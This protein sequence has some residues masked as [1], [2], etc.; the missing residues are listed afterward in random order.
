MGNKA[1][2]EAEKL[3]YFGDELTEEQATMFRALAAR[4]NYLSPD[5]P[6]ISFA[7]KELCREF[8]CPTNKSVERL[9][10]CARYLTNNPRLVW[11]FPFDQVH[12]DI[13]IYCDTDVG[14][15][16]RTRRSTREDLAF[17][18][19]VWWHLAVPRPSWEAFA[20]LRPKALAS[21]HCLLIWEER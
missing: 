18:G 11:K 13:K 2:N 4:C 5:R 1:V 9:K 21:G 20:K 19:L 6:D 17:V 7:S 14:G 15:C 10:R 3:E 16:V 8:A 12:S